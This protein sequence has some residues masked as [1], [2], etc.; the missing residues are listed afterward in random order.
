MNPVPPLGA[1]S[2]CT[3]AEG[4][5]HGVGRT[6]T[7]PPA[8]R[9]ASPSFSRT[10]KGLT[11]PQSAAAHRKLLFFDHSLCCLCPSLF[12]C[13]QPAHSVK[14]QRWPFPTRLLIQRAIF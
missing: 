7:Y 9:S 14:R 11:T 2:P 10:V 13:S 6:R 5:N 12:L 1:S 8:L 3:K 4:E